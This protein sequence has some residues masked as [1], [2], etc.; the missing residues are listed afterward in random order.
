[1]RDKELVMEILHQMEG[2]VAK[3]VVRFQA[4]HQV[5]DFTERQG[6]IM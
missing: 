1:M 4:I 5:A 6:L 2:A 3:I